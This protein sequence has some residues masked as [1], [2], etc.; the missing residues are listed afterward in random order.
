[1]KGAIWRSRTKGL[2]KKMN[3]YQIIALMGES[4]SGKDTV[5]N[6]NIK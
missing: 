3:K 4:G 5:L 1:M 2:T 6:V